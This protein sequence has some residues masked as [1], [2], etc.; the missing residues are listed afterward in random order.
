MKQRLLSLLLLCALLLGVLA[1][2][3]KQTDSANSTDP[4]N[5]TSQK[6]DAAA[7]DS[8]FASKYVYQAE[9]L[10]VPAEID[11]INA[12]CVSGSTAYLYVGVTENGVSRNALYAYD[13]DAKTCA[14]LPG[15]SESGNENSNIQFLVPAADGGLWALEAQY[16]FTDTVAAG[17]VD[18]ATEADEQAAEEVSSS[19]SYRLLHFA[20]DGTQLDAFSPDL[21]VFGGDAY[22]SSFYVDSAGNLYLTDYSTVLVLDQNGSQLLTLENDGNSDLEQYNADTVGVTTY[23]SSTDGSRS[24]AFKPIDLAAK[25]WGAEMKMPADAW[26]LLPGNDEYDL[27]YDYN[28]NLYGWHADTDTAEKVV[29]WMACDVDSNNLQ[30]YTILPDGR[31][32]AIS[33]SYDEADASAELILLNRVDASAVTE[34]VEL[35]LACMNLDWNLRSQIVKF[36]RENDKY[37]IVVKDYSEYSSMTYEGSGDMTMV[38]QNNDGLTKLNTE[39][40]AGNVPDLL[41]TDGLPVRQYAAKGL[42][43][44]LYSYIDSDIGRDAFVS[45]VLDADSESGK[46]YELPLGFQIVTAE[47]LA[48]VVGSY[49]SWTL[50]ALQDA[51]TKLNP[52]ATI[53]NVDATRSN[54]LAYC[55][56]M[57][58]DSFVDWENQT[59][60]FDSQDFIDYLNFAAQ[61]QAEF[62]FSTFDWSEYEQDA[63]RMRNGD[64]L[65]NLYGTLYG[66]DSVYENFAELGGDLCYIGF[67]SRS[68][69]DGSA[70]ALSSAVAITSACR[71]KDAAWSFIR[72]ALTDEYQSAQTY[73]P[74]TKSAF[75]KAAE[76][77][78]EK[79][80]AYDENGDI[81][82][83]ENGEPVEVSKGGF[84]YGNGPMI[85][86]Y[87]MTQE[88]YDTVKALIAATH[89]IMRY[90]DSLTEII[91]DET[92]AFFAGEKTAEETAQLIQN[93]V[94]L[95]MAEQG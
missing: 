81:L 52:D 12:S 86:I 30:N 53:F 78:M 58:A 4:V 35:T 27:F 45:E 1:G 38:T 22:L 67:P 29:D 18:T 56:Y 5:T 31:V 7:D 39:I 28:Q 82:L 14:A 85:E 89:Q 44:D 34:K 8:V 49:D 40:M 9:Y 72:S 32:F 41:L 55:L 50:T 77:A 94:Q 46:L 79:N 19:T 6:T 66:F 61:F 62:D 36:N 43:E 13:L 42:L 47:G 87:A 88:Q 73:F 80:Y 59:A 51:M 10:D 91:N 84:S 3:G 76:Q 26:N 15:Y 21:S 92:G 75:E 25:G 54:V 69:H 37:H 90:D 33:M 63:V 11:Y 70:F 17:S 48:S 2:C 65:L 71:D 68:G 83:D 95:Y 24:L 16:H 23:A 57:N 64:Q 93:R 60:N 74:I 20:A